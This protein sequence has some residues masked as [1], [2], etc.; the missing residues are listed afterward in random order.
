MAEPGEILGANAAE[1]IHWYK[2]WD[3]ILD[4]SRAPFY[5]WFSGAEGNTCYNVLDVHVENG[6][7][8]QTALIYDC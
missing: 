6:R 5:R 1:T 8:E 4:T 7:A 2:K 3:K